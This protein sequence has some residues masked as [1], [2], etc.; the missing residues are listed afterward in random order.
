MTA[1]T[2]DR[3]V[4]PAGAFG[5]LVKPKFFSLHRDRPS[6]DRRGLDAMMNAACVRFETATGIAFPAN[7]PVE[8]PWYGMPW[9]KNFT[10]MELV[11]TAARASGWLNTIAECPEQSP[12]LIRVMGQTVSFRG[13]GSP[14]HSFR[15][16]RVIDRH[17]SPHECER[18]VRRTRAH[19]NEMLRAYG[20]R[21]SASALAECLTMRFAS[22]RRAARHAAAL[23]VQHHLNHHQIGEW[24]YPHQPRHDWDVLIAARGLAR[25]L[26]IDPARRH[27]VQ[28]QE[29]SLLER[30]AKMD[31]AGLVEDSTD[32]VTGWL[33]LS[34]ARVVHGITVTE[35]WT[36]HSQR[37]YHLVRRGERTW[38]NNNPQGESSRAARV[39]Y[40]RDYRWWAH[41]Y[42]LTGMGFTNSWPACPVCDEDIPAER[43]SARLALEAWAKQDEQRRRDE[44]N[45]LRNRPL[46]MPTDR[47]VLVY[48]QDSLDSGNCL[49]GS[50]AFA[51]Q[52]GW[53]GRRFV[54][55]QWLIETGDQRA[56]N[57]A[58]LALRRHIEAT[59]IVPEAEQVSREE[60]ALRQHAQEDATTAAVY[61]DWLEERGRANET[62]QWRDRAL[63]GTLTEEV[64][65]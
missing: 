54:P 47:S 12:A 27:F 9:R 49:P 6:W 4:R 65:S 23:T 51:Q 39:R 31:A 1:L 32:G 48:L 8:H 24:A 15:L 13:A 58:M 16:W 36:A 11:E 40:Q 7:W 22:P 63:I 35:L 46:E 45:R 26:A 60:S 19:A 55:A 29:G 56:R 14:C 10:R 3:L 30:L 52:H 37:A 34:S 25:F 18:V 33:D 43:V 38:H 20:V 61:A 50:E 53:Q 64:S 44:E 57:A 62:Q 21:V 17:P 2:L 59:A 41:L 42:S 28:A 5:W